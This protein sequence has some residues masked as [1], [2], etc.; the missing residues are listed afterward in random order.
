MS[1]WK[2]SATSPGTGWI[3]RRNAI[4]L[5]MEFGS[6]DQIIFAGV[7]STVIVSQRKWGLVASVSLE[8]RRGTQWA[9]VIYKSPLSL[10]DFPT[11]VPGKRKK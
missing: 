3:V 8:R 4:S 11:N 10:S 6:T 5:T 7:P 1:F 9:Y 2:N